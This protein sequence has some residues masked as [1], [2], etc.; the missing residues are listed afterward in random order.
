MWPYFRKSTIVT[1]VASTSI[2]QN[3]TFSAFKESDFYG[4][5]VLGSGATEETTSERYYFL[6][7]LCIIY[8]LPLSWSVCLHLG[9]TEHIP[10][11]ASKISTWS[12]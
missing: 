4:K 9:I 1:Q 12:E 11:V 6:R 10:E 8:Q 5:Y 3:C 2:F 7:K